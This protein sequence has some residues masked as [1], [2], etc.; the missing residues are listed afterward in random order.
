MTTKEIAA[1]LRQR[2][3]R[4]EISNSAYEAYLCHP[5]AAAR[6]AL[7]ERIRD[8]MACCGG[9]G[10]G[11]GGEKKRVMSFGTPRP[12]ATSAPSLNAPVATPAVTRTP[13]PFDC[14]SEVSN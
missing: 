4:T 2:A 9:G 10:G 13:A 8:N 11:S 7:V 5:T 3:Q 6:R 1:M 14:P 12:D